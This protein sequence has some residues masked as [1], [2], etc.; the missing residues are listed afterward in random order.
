MRVRF[1]DGTEVLAHGRLEVVPPERPRN[2]DAALYLDSRWATDPG[3]TWPYT[4][5]PW[6]DFEPPEDE[7]E[8]F[9]AL[10][11]IWATA[12]RGKLVEIA[13]DGGTGRTGT[14][15][16]CLAVLAGIQPG[17]AVGWVREN[18]HPWAVE[19]PEQEAFV[20]RFAAW[21]GNQGT[22]T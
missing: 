1:P 6:D 12:R 15:L 17:N 3:V 14:A 13:C 5:I 2:P 21:S 7:E 8:L 11:T 20:D 10:D 4:L 19:V 22:S 18:Y 9:R 16:A